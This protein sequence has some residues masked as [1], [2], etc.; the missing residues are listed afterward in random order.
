MMFNKFSFPE[1]DERYRTLIYDLGQVRLMNEFGS[2]H[3]PRPV[4]F[5]VFAF[6]KLPEKEDWR[7]RLAFNPADFQQREPVAAAE[8]TRGLGYLKAKPK[9]VVKSRYLAL[10]WEPDF[11]PPAFGV[12]SPVISGSGFPGG[13]PG[14]NAGGPGGQAA[15]NPG[16]TNNGGSNVGDAGNAGNGGGT[17]GG[18]TG[19]DGQGGNNSSGDGGGTDSSGQQQASS[20]T[21]QSN[22]PFTGSPSANGVGIT[23]TP[24]SP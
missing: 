15:T 17:G 24:N 22:V 2:V 10:R 20:Q 13:S 3:S 18:G 12:S 9:A 5:E 6:E 11:N 23:N 16:H 4:R 19:G 14:S 7:G 1:S 21:S 8:D